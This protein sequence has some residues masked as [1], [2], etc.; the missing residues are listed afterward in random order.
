[1]KRDDI[2]NTLK[3]KK[4][5]S[6]V[7]LIRV[8]FNLY[9]KKILGELK[10]LSIQRKKSTKISLVVASEMEVIFVVN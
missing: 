3:S 5:L 2:W 6:E 4:L 7:I 10:H 1:M 8:L 9:K